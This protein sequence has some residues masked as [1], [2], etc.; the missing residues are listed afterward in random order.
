MKCR[1]GA[2]TS[3][4][5]GPRLAQRIL[6]QRS[7]VKTADRIGL[8][9]QG[10]NVFVEEVAVNTILRTLMQLLRLLALFQ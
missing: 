4:G 1:A 8:Q 3:T 2:S 5:S 9:L 10:A 6:V 7:Q